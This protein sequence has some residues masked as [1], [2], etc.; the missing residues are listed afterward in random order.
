MRCCAAVPGRRAR[1]RLSRFLATASAVVALVLVAAPAAGAFELG[2]TDPTFDS[3]DPGTR[4][5]WLNRAVDAR[6]G[7]VLLGATWSAI[8]PAVP[9]AGFN[10]EDPG[11]PAYSWGTL[12]AAAQEATS[13]G[14]RVAILVGQAP[15]WAEGPNRPSTR[16][17]ASGTWKPDPA[18]LRQ[19]AGAIATRYSGGFVGPSGPLPRVR[20]WQLWAEPNLSV[21]LT[22]QFKGRRE[23]AAS[24]YRKMLNAFYSGIKSVSASNRVITGGTA[25][26]GDL[27]GG[28]RTQPALFW[29]AL[30]CLKG[31]KLRPKRCRNPARFDIA[32]H[33]PINVGGPRRHAQSRN[34]IS[35]P[36]FRRLKRILAKAR[37]TGRVKPRG[38]KPLWATEIWWDS[39]PPD[40]RGV[41]QRRHARWLEESFYLLWKQGLKVVVWFQI[42]DAAPDPSF[43]S[44]YQTGLFLDDG[45][46]KLA[47][48]AF[49]FPFVAER[50][51]KRTIRVWGM[52]P[53]PG[54]V[55]VQRKA[56]GGW[57]TVKRLGAGGD[58]VFVGKIRLRGSAK[59]RAQADGE[60]SLAW[61]QP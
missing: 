48:K 5:S 8:A 27:P 39:K 55:L 15:V 24:H 31:Q 54:G 30:L 51:G 18:A 46:P 29:R 6:V 60:T 13:R 52:A 35:T 36:D 43:G 21:Y 22:P 25:P 3:P 58:R 40:P 4:S 41:P 23:V 16:V 20:Y 61:S 45:T 2:L 33:N 32:A 14:L 49:R 47:Y 34:D 12:D 57:R 28:Q 50:L 10:P 44:T 26:Y 37:R 11:S 42:R 38:K 19:F 1:A 56:M 59:L 53:S 17:A 9:P 7:V